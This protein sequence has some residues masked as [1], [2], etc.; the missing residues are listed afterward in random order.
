MKIKAFRQLVLVLVVVGLNLGCS[1]GRKVGTTQVFSQDTTHIDKMITVKYQPKLNL[2]IG[3]SISFPDLKMN[4]IRISENEALVQSKTEVVT[5]KESFTQ[6]VATKTVDKSKDKSQTD[7][8][9]KEKV[10][11]NSETDSNNKAKKSDNEKTKDNHKQVKRGFP[12]VILLVSVLV[13]LA[14]FFIYKKLF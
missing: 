14:L 5:Q 9:N 4:I 1:A 8:N 13:G 12:W 11:D 6:F 2:K 3:E 7:S 10:V